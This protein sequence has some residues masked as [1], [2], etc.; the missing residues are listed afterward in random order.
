[1]KVC[2]I[3]GLLIAAIFLGCADET[4]APPPPPKPTIKVELNEVGQ[5]MVSFIHMKGTTDK[6]EY[7][8]EV[9]L[10]T[11]A[12]LRAYKKQVDFLV[13][14]LDEAERQMEIHELEVK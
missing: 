7:H 13:K 9:E 10:H 6:Y 2:Q 12:D 11:L 8:S 3:I 5:V 4:T 14:Q 1:M